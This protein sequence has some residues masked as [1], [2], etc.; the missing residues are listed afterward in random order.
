MNLRKMSLAATALISTIAMAQTPS[1]TFL[2]RPYH[3][4]SFSQT[5]RPLWEFVPSGETI[6]N[7]TTLVSVVDRSDAHTL[8]DL[9]RVS[10]GV[11]ANYKAHHAVILRATTSHDAAG[12]PFNYIVVA[13]D[14]PAKHRY[15]LNFVKIA[16][17]PKNAYVLIYGARIS[18]PV[19]YRTKAKNFLD[20]RSSE[21]G[22][23]LESA[24][25]PAI[26]AFPRRPF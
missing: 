16:L 24:P 17:G 3:L 8:P 14:G 21:I 7:W 15:E 5:D 10:E 18:D 23:A 2:S 22:K 12:K 20:Q 26:A 19:D 1:I 4:G 13:F 6:D 11:M 25:A 9:D